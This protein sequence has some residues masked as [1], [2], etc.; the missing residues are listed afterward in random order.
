MTIKNCGECPFKEYNPHYSMS[1][2]SGYDCTNP[3]SKGT[4]IANDIGS[5]EPNLEVLSIPDWCGLDNAL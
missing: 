4:R 3:D 5:K 1:Y 2:N